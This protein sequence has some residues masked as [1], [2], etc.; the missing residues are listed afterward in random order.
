[1]AYR[2]WLFLAGLSG[3][4]A[5]LMGA[6]I[7]H[8]SPPFDPGVVESLSA[9]QLYHMLHSLALLGVAVLL[10]ASDGR[11]GVVVSLLLNLAGAAFAGGIILFSFGIYGAF[12]NGAIV[13]AQTVPMGGMLFIAGWVLLALS[14]FGVEGR[15]KVSGPKGGSD[16]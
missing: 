4:F 7:K 1:M 2:I 9:G 5:V 3:A 13:H 12:T 6:A 10:L 11:R 16:S 14:A 8:R 15:P